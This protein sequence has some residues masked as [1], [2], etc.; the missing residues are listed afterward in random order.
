MLQQTSSTGRLTVTLPSDREICITRAFNAPARLV[1]DAWTQPEHVK[2]WFGAC[3]SMTMTVC[4]IDLRVGGLWR[5]VLH[6]SSNGMD[7]GFSGEYREIVLPERLVSTE[8]YEPVPGSDHLNTLTLVEQDG[9][10]MMHILIQHS[11]KEQRDGHLQSGMETGLCEALNRV[12]DLLESED[13]QS[14]A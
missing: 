9:K 10:T 14:M 4:E 7:H 8:R 13:L 2:R 5:Y 3:R 1:F 6:D 11:S 12:D